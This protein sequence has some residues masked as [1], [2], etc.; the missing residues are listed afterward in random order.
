MMLLPDNGASQRAAPEQ[1]LRCFK[2]DV[3]VSG[4]LLPASGSF[5]AELQQANGRVRVRGLRSEP[6]HNGMEGVVMGQ[7]AAADETRWNVRCDNGVRLC[8]KPHNIEPIL[9]EDC[10]MVSAFA[11]DCTI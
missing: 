2:A 11:V 10:S 1:P 9:P 7:T 8:L 6:Q 5:E 3:T 4:G